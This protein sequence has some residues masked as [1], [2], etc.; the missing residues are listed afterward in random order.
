MKTAIS[1]RTVDNITVIMIAFSSFKNFL[2]PK[3]T[4]LIGHN[5]LDNIDIGRKQYIFDNSLI[6]NNSFDLDN[7]SF[8]LGE[9]LNIANIDNKKKF[10]DLNSSNALSKNNSNNSK[11]LINKR[12]NI[13]K[14][15]PVTCVAIANSFKN[16]LKVNSNNVLFEK[17][18]ISNNINNLSKLSTNKPSLGLRKQDTLHTSRGLTK[19]METFYKKK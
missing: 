16:Q 10:I 3:R 13:L 5:S 2:F 6:E 7:R 9:E 15:K 17:S 12:N 4:D 1:K 19:N 18:K 8:S 11:T 14:K